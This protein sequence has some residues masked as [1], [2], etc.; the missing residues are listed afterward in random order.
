VQNIQKYPMVSVKEAASALGIDERT[1]RE[2]L[3]NQEWK[4]EKKSIGLKEK[5]FMHRG[6]LER[7]LARLGLSMPLDRATIQGIDLFDS[8]II[9]AE[10]SDQSKNNYSPEQ[11]PSSNRLEQVVKTIT[12]TITKPLINELSQQREVIFQLQR[13]VVEKDNQLKLLPDLQKQTSEQ[14]KLVEAKHFE[15]EAL[16]K[17]IAAL[18]KP[19]W[20]KLLNKQSA[21]SL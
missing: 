18:Q 4:G 17:Q 2:K 11:D 20:K 5:W 19:W 14:Q 8:G 12:E 6:E 13:E 16:R 7:Q 10:I 3:S 9:D 15:V 21:Q 1:I